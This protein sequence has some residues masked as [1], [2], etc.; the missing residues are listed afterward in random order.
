LIHKSIYVV[1]ILLFC[2]GF[3]L[4]KNPVLRII[5]VDSFPLEKD[6]LECR[7]FEEAIR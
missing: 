7:A 5:T 3:S 4:A 1:F 2:L 6:S